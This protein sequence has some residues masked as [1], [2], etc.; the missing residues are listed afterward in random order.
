MAGYVKGNESHLRVLIG[1][2]AKACMELDGISEENLKHTECIMESL[3]M[4]CRDYVRKDIE[5][6]TEFMKVFLNGEE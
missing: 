2:I 5:P 1:K 6:K 4:L 3:E